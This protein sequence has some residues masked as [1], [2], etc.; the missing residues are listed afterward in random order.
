M[1]EEKTKYQ[2][3]TLIDLS[4]EWEKGYGNGADCIP[5]SG[6]APPG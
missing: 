3:P 5:G 4:D 1:T 6:I 2:K